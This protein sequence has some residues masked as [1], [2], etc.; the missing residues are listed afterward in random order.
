MEESNTT[1]LKTTAWEA[2]R[3]VALFV[4]AI[5]NRYSNKTKTFHRVCVTKS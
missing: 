4:S 2:K 5:G 1:P 3:L